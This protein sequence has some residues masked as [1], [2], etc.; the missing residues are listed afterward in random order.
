MTNYG[1]TDDRPETITGQHHQNQ[2]TEQ[3]SSSTTT[4]AGS[5]TATRAHARA[6]EA[7]IV[8]A[9]LHGQYVDCCEYYARAFGRSP[10]PGIQ[11]ELATRIRDGMGADVIRAAI[12]DTMIAPRPSWAY[13]AAIL[14][15]CDLEG[16]R[17]MADW[18]ASK[19]RFQAAKNPA[20]NY[21]QR[22]YT[23]D[24]FGQDFFVDLDKYAGGDNP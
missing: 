24:M 13:M 11:R 15:R 9:M 5:S 7:E 10:A 6:R 22:N 3:S 23:E 14:R 20:L 17:T 2:Q 4:A 21:E 16:I 1:I 18:I 8:A 19:E 12:D